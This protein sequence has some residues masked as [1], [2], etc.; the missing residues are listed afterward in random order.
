MTDVPALR[1]DLLR[2]LEA[3]KSSLRRGQDVVVCPIIEAE[4]DT[5]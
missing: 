1:K 2:T 5:E 4:P 3:A